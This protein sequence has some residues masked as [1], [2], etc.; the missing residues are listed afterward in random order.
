MKSFLWLSWLVFAA[1]P[2][3][4]LP[5][6]GPP[7]DLAPYF[8]EMRQNHPAYRAA[9]LRYQ[10]ALAAVPA[11]T[12]LPDPQVSLGIFVEEVQT[13][14]GPQKQRLGVRQGL[15]WPGKRAL[16]GE[17]AAAEA[18]V[19]AARREGVARDLEKQFKQAFAGYFYLGR[20]VAI[21]A[22][23]LALLEDLERVVTDRYET[24]AAHY[25]DLI[26]I[27]MEIEQLG[28]RLASQKAAAQPVRAQLNTLL[29]RP[30]D[31][32][33]AF[34]PALP[35]VASLPE[36]KGTDAR[37]VIAQ[38]HPDLQVLAAHQ[39]KNR[40]KVAL[41]D[42]QRR[43][44]FHVGLDWINT[45]EAVMPNTR[46]SGVDPVLLS[47]GVNLPL[48]RKKNRAA[49]DRARFTLEAV[50]S[51]QRDV[52]TR[53][54]SLLQQ[55]LFQR[56]DAERKMDLFGERLVPKAR[57]SLAVITSDFQTGAGSYLDLIEAEQD[58]LTFLLAYHEAEQRRFQ[59][60]A[61]I[62]YLLGGAPAAP[63][64]QGGTE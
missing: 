37:A 16:A 19:L 9:D 6:A 36:L 62:E 35:A 55:A 20:A 15:P 39:A 31:A 56:D 42:L 64:N 63:A 52:G 27:Q 11:A 5:P 29:G 60:V 54:E 61:D 2:A 12:A 50:E 30:L 41:A 26:R 47:V 18:E 38:H 21:T 59:A 10:A 13:R 57:E 40:T 43:P 49:V 44:D 7:A 58:L 34:P 3:A 1:A 17:V 33:F 51:Q 24:S 25:N 22:E 8:A 46:G 23:H 4:A 48:W 28:E 32:P 53:A 14:V 45:G